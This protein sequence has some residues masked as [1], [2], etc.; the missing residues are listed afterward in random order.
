[1][2]ERKKHHHPHWAGPP[3]PELSWSSW[4]DLFEHC[5]QTNTHTHT[6]T[7]THTRNLQTKV[8]TQRK[9]CPSPTLHHR[10][11]SFLTTNAKRNR[12][13]KHHVQEPPKHLSTK[14]LPP[15][16]PAIRSLLR[17]K[18]TKRMKVAPG[19]IVAVGGADLTLMTP[20]RIWEGHNG[21]K[22][23]CGRKRPTC[24]VSFACATSSMTTFCYSRDFANALYVVSKEE[25]RPL[26]MGRFWICPHSTHNRSYRDIEDMINDHFDE[27]APCGFQVVTRLGCCMV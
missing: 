10:L 23:C 22:D 5:V 7:H 8:H 25:N 13:V 14:T 12:I 9:T 20:N 27:R 2:V 24:L 11:F 15:G 4:A 19:S 18:L 21:G 26:S 1:M 3:L 17:V 16:I 6:H